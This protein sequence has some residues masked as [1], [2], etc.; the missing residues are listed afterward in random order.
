MSTQSMFPNQQPANQSMAFEFPKP[1]AEKYRPST[2]PEFIG[3]DKVKKILAAFAA[4]PCVSAWVF[5]GPAGTGKTSMAQALNTAING[6]F[7]HVPSQKCDTRAIA[8]ST[9]QCW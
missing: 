2:I 1:L 6:E 4:R 5:V 8:D 3:L 9:R 7:H